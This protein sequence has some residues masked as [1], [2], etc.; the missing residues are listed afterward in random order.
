MQ[1]FRY[2]ILEN[3]LRSDFSSLST[4]STDYG[5]WYKSLKISFTSCLSSQKHSIGMCHSRSLHLSH[6]EQKFGELKESN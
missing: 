3:V 6:P 1:I 5:D 2:V 4:V